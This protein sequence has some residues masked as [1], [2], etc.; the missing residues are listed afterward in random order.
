V[1]LEWK[2]H[3]GH[4]DPSDR[5]PDRCVLHT[6]D[7]LPFGEVVAVMDALYS[8][9]REMVALDGERVAASVFNMAFAIR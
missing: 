2:E 4:Q 6:E 7:R 9:K 1:A 8:A 5:T 3:G